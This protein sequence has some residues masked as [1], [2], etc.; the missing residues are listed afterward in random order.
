M[1]TRGQLLIDDRLIGP[2]FIGEPAGDHDGAAGD[3][4]HARVHRQEAEVAP[5]ADRTGRVGA[6]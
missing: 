1:A 4:A 6:G 3:S 2:L 5:A